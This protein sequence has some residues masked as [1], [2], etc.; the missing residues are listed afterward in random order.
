VTLGAG[1]AQ[2]VVV[3]AVAKRGRDAATPWRTHVAFAGVLLALS[4]G[5]KS[6]VEAI[7]SAAVER[8]WASIGS[9]AEKRKTRAYFDAFPWGDYFPNDLRDAATYLAFKTTPDE[10]VQIYGF[11]PYF[12]FLAKRKSASPVIYGFELNVDA[13]LKGGPGARPSAETKEWLVAYRNEAEALVLTTVE[14]SPPAAFALFDRAPFTF[15]A[16]A[17][18]DFEAHCPRLFAWMTAHYERGPSFGTV[19]LWMRHDVMAR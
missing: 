15:P 16:D 3:G 17:E 4:V 5:A 11:D 14:A 6:F 9:T 12:L 1:V 10:R 19:R 2:L 7:D 13:A 8:H 18:R